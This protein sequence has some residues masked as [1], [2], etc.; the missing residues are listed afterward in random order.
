M[1]DIQ[2]LQGSLLEDIYRFGEQQTSAAHTQVY[3]NNLLASAFR[4]LSIAYPCTRQLIGDEALKGLA[5]MNL[6]QQPLQTADWSEFGQLLA[7]II[8]SNEAFESY[9]YLS[10][11]AHYE[12]LIFE[13]ERSRDELFDQSSVFKLQESDIDNVYIRFQESFRLLESP[14]PVEDIYRANL[15]EAADTDQYLQLAKEKLE[16]DEYEERLMIYRC[17]YKADS[18]A[19]AKNEFAF[20]SACMKG[21]S[22]GS[23]LDTIEI[24]AHRTAE[25]NGLDLGNVLNL[26]VQHQAISELY[27]Q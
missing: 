4:S 12:A 18:T 21:L 25:N 14:Y 24:E 17:R 16:Q 26:L 9:P 6:Q 8:A 19:V 2:T 23:A 10:D 27:I 1:S 7:K 20:I 13:S 15:S 22:I 5:A 3:Q 11:V